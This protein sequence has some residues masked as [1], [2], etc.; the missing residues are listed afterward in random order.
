MPFAFTSRSLPFWQHS[1]KNG[2][3]LAALQRIDILKAMNE[4]HPEQVLMA[5]FEIPTLETYLKD[6]YTLI[7][8]EE[9]FRLF[10][11]DDLAPK[12]K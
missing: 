5:R 2:W 11:R 12:V 4:Y 1:L 7:S 9:F 8:S 6:H 10:I 3:I